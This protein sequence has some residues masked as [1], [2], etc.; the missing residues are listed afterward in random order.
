MNVLISNDDGI[1]ASGI[2]VM[3]EIASEIGDPVVFAPFQQQ[4]GVGHQVT[5]DR[6]IQIDQ[7][8][9]NRFAVHGTPADCVRIAVSEF[10]FDFKMMLSGINSGGNLGVDVLMS[11]TAAAA[12][13]ASYFG[14]E[15]YAVS[16]YRS[17]QFVS[18]WD[19][20]KALARRGIEFV[21]G[22]SGSVQG[23]W[24][25]NLPCVA[26]RSQRGNEVPV[27]LCKLD[28]NPHKISYQ[29]QENRFQYAGVYQDRIRDPSSDVD[30]CF[31]GAVTVT[32]CQ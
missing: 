28:R 23:F 27:R 25:I 16:Q 11:G 12:R 22:K 7:V 31:G 19:I 10:D 20:S 26:E 21:K 30:L 18:N 24:N 14:I 9:E 3:E 1:D 8:G 5:I 15:S 4:S 2:A 6:S 32:R 13:E 17:K 29:K